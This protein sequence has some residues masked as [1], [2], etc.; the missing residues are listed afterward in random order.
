MDLVVKEAAGAGLRANVGIAATLAVCTLG[1]Q[2]T[3]PT[4]LGGELH[5]AMML[6][7]GV[8]ETP[9]YARNRFAW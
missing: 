5:D 2:Y 4:T 7:G 1:T 6:T 8:V 9:G 3:L